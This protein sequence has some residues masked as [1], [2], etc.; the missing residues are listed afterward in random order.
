M[1]ELSLNYVTLYHLIGVLHFR[2]C[3]YKPYMLFY[4]LYIKYLHM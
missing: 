3:I 4:Y 1:I 2:S